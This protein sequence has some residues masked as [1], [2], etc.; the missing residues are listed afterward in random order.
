MAQ[1]A[2]NL[3]AVANDG[4]GDT[5]R[6]GGD[7]INDNF[8]ELYGDRAVTMTASEALSA[9]HFVNIHAST[10][11]KIRKANATDDTKPCNGFVPAGILSAAAG[12]MLTPGVTITGLSSLTPG[13]PYYLDTT[14][15]AITA[16]PPSS[17]GNLV[18]EVGIAISATE[19]LFNP[20]Q[21]I[22]L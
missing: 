21:G 17:S 4:T 16:T 7:K 14:G 15:G 9:G 19:L 1:Q 8:T 5:F 6:D 18:Q 11:A 3:G 12:A 20:R 13:V 2:I 22:T 10:G